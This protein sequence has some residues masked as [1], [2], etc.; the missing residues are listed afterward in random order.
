MWLK[1]LLKKIKDKVGKVGKM[2]GGAAVAILVYFPV[3]VWYGTL[4][5]VA[6]WVIDYGTNNAITWRRQYRKYL[7]YLYGDGDDD[8]GD[9]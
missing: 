4:Y 9:D 8:A 3:L 7:A 6:E 1:T 5:R 2:T